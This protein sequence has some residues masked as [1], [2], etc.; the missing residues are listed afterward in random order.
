MSKSIKRTVKYLGLILGALIVLI[1]GAGIYIY[2]LLPKPIGTPTILQAELFSKPNLLHYT[3]KTF[4]FASATELATL[5]KERKATSYEITMAHLSQIK[6]YNFRYNALIWL[7]EEEALREAQLADD[8]VKRGDSTGPLHGVPVTVKEM[9]WVKGSPSTMNAK[10]FGFIAPEDGPLVRQLKKA[11]AIILGTTNVPYM[12]ADYQTYGEVY[13][14][15]KNPYDTT[16]TPGGSTGGGAAAVAAGFS[17]LE[18]GSDL[19]GSIRVPA[20]FCGLYGLKPSFGLTNIT[21]GVG[22]DT[23]NQFNHFALASAGPLARNPEDIELMWEVLK[24]AEPDLRFQTKM[25]FQQ[26]PPKSLSQ[27][28]VAWIDEYPYQ[29]GV[30]NSG[31]EVKASIKQLVD[32]LRTSGLEIKQGAPDLYDEMTQSFLASFASIMMQGQPWVIRKLFGM[33]MKGMDDKTGNFD[34]FYQSLNDVSDKAWE[35]IQAQRNSLI[36][37]WEIFFKDHDVLICPI[38]YG[39]AFTKCKTGEEIQGDDRKIPYMDYVG[40]SYIFN[41]TGH[42]CMVIPMGINQDGLPIAI[43]LVGKFYS[44]SDLIRF[45]KEIK[46]FTPG[47][48]KPNIPYGI[49]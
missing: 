25:D 34:A 5:I 35:K 10:M 16:R 22:P 11:G 41:A 45:A 17:P 38:T 2:S 37:N 26:S 4:I 30:I 23:V 1:A 6:N 24:R 19:G 40:F 36:E 12:L 27:Y 48:I 39:P 9:F 21:M 43:Q 44:E 20:A 29:G 49:K 46:P 42:P 47:F 13:P 28:R 31:I 18:L 15:G 7:R 3:Q 32:S 8:A 33:S 14:I